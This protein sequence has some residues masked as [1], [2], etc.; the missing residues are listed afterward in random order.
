[1]KLGDLVKHKH[2]SDLE[3]GIILRQPNRMFFEVFWGAPVRD[4]YGRS[5]HKRLEND[6]DLVI[7]SEAR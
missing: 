1:M 6:G 5:S 4:R 2:Y 3:V 7:I